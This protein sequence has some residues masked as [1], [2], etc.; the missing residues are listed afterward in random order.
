MCDVRN[1]NES[2]F[3]V[4][5]ILPSQPLRCLDFAESIFVMSGTLLS[6]T[7]VCLGPY[8]CNYGNFLTY[9][10]LSMLP[11]LLRVF[12]VLVTFHFYRFLTCCACSCRFAP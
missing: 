11:V 1:V 8:C 7:L 4:F 2:N 12:K 6:Q 9:E 10:S 5:G 3:V